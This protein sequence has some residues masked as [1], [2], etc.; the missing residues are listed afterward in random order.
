MLAPLPADPGAIRRVAF[1]GTPGI[2]VP[3]L[4]SLVG[5]ADENGWEIVRVVSG[6]DKRRG[7]GSATSPTP[8]KQ[9]ALDAG[10]R[11]DRISTDVADL[12]VDHRE[13]PIDLGIVVAF[14]QLIRPNVLAEIP[15]VNIHF[16]DLPR[17]RGAAPV[18]RAILTGDLASAVVL[19]TV[20]EGLDEGVVWA[21][22]EVAIGVDDTLVDLWERMADIGASLLVEAMAAGFVDGQPQ[23]GEVVYARKLTTEDRRLDWS[24]SAEELHRVVRVGGAWTTFRGE[25]FKVHDAKVA[26]NGSG[27]AGEIDGVTVSCKDG[28]LELVVVQPAGKPRMDVDAWRNG[29]QPDGERLGE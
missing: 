1:L 28:A 21:R 25:R 6:A 4:K 8:V 2:A 18:E 26:A 3:A 29:A 13:S 9:A 14:G 5:A 11:S 10:I 7:R 16:S 23:I 12:L 20:A 17:W 24:Q 27:V 19:M 15:M 22:R